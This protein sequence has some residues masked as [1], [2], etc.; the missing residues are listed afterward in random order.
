VK[1]ALLAAAILLAFGGLVAAQE[2]KE[3][4]AKPAPAPPEIDNSLPGFGMRNADLP[5]GPGRS[6]AEYACLTCHS[7]DIP[8]QQRLNEKQWTATVTKMA[9]WG[10]DVQDDKRAEL[11]AYLVKNFGPDN[12]RFK[13]VVTR[14]VGR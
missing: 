12:D 6:T 3:P 4:K 11:I 1:R 14:P 9:G 13:P 10:A 5:P 8:R 7:P 2:G